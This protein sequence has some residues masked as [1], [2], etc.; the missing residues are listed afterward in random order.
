METIL[1]KALQFILSLS[2][3]VALHE[4]GH[5]LFAKLFKTRVTR[6]YLFANWGFHLFS[7]YDDWFRKLCHKP[8]VTERGDEGQNFW[9]WLKNQYY[10]I[11]GRKDQ[12]K[13]KNIGNKVY[14][15]EHGTEYG[16]GWLPIGGYVSI[17]GMIDETNQKLSSE[18]QPWEF[19]SKPAWQRLLIMLGGVLMNFLVAFA[20]YA[21][22]LYTWGE[23]YVKTT[24]MTYGMK[25]NEQAKADGFCDG[26]LILGV[27]HRQQLRLGRAVFAETFDGLHYITDHYIGI[28]GPVGL[29]ERHLHLLKRVVQ[30]F[31]LHQQ[32]LVYLTPKRLVVVVT[33]LL[34][35]HIGAVE[36]AV[37]H[38][39]I[40]GADS[41]HA[42]VPTQMLFLDAGAQRTVV[43]QLLGQSVLHKPA[44]GEPFAVSGTG[45]SGL[46]FH[47][48]LRIGGQTVRKIQ[49]YK[50]QIVCVGKTL[51]QLFVSRVRRLAFVLVVREQRLDY[52]RSHH[53]SIYHFL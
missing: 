50:I 17:A 14:K 11:T 36:L 27:E 20:I 10:L 47:L 46:L 15:P 24:D 52:T 12:V 40:Y 3:L 6:F 9:M 16:I 33:A 4:G 21:G 32:M 51:Q 42:A 19:R 49:Q 37:H 34:C 28:Y 8:L 39:A 43:K 35:G 25:F 23:S 45:T 22:V 41:R 31:A 29:V 53:R 44:V 26:D 5:F 13:T 48:L 2:L 38:F 1:I 7:T 30:L 18:P